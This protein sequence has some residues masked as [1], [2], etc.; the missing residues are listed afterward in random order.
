MFIIFSIR[1]L[2]F[3]WIFHGVFEENF[4]NE[5]FIYFKNFLLPIFAVFL[6]NNDSMSDDNLIKNIL[7]YLLIQT[8]SHN[9]TSLIMIT[10]I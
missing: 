4:S 7:E 9:K 3:V 6:N 5:Y 2:F 8:F 10:L 1:C